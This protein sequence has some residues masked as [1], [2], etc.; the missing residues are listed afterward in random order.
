[1]VVKLDELESRRFFLPTLPG[2]LKGHVKGRPANISEMNALELYIHPGYS[3]VFNS[4]TIYEMYL[5]NEIPDMTV[6]GEPMVDEMG[7]WIQKDWNT[8]MHSVGEMVTY[9]KQEYKRAEIDNQYPEGWSRFGGYKKIRF[10]ATGFFRTHF[11][12]KRWW[13]VDPDGY[14]FFSNGV[15]YGNR[16]GVHGFV[17]GMKIF[18]WL[19]ER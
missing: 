1:M 17:D 11:D 2:T 15:C 10:D 13:L 5:S 6:I 4:F 8:K 14:A 12:G 16:M 19:P 7:Q 9:L 18:F 3:H